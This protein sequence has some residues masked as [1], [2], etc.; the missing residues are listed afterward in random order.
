M[1][2]SSTARFKATRH[3]RSLG[4]LTALAFSH[5]IVSR[6]PSGAAV[7][8]LAR[9]FPKAITARFDRRH[10]ADPAN[11]CL[12]YRALPRADRGER[13]AP[14]LGTENWMVEFILADPELRE[15]SHNG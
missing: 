14:S 10:R 1:R 12:S 15:Q 5:R 9:R 6:T 7:F 3:Q 2:L 8:S 4:A 11:D 13:P